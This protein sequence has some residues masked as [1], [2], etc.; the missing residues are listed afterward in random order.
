MTDTP[1]SRRGTDVVEELR[2]LMTGFRGLERRIGDHFELNAT[3]TAALEIIARVPG[4][5]P[6]RLVADLNVSRGAV[7]FVLDRLEAAGLIT[8][9]P[10]P[11]DRRGVVLRPS[12]AAVAD[13]RTIMVGIGTRLQAHF[14]ALPPEHQDAVLDFLREVRT[15]FGVPEPDQR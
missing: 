1:S 3:D 6:S 5:T 13:V 8:R 2:Q 10:N 12:P 4:T 14:A 11:A 7:T 15:S 9:E